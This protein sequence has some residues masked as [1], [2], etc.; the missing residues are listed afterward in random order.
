M[1]SAQPVLDLRLLLPCLTAWAV[2]AWALSWSGA[3][4]ATGVALALALLAV[5]VAAGV[6]YRG[7]HARAS[8]RRDGP[9]VLALTLVATV[10]V[11]GSSAAHEWRRQLGPV[12]R[13]AERGAMVRA[14]GVVLT[15]PR[16]RAGRPSGDEG[17]EPPQQAYL[18]VRL[19]SVDSRGVRTRV[20][21]PVFVR[22]DAAWAEV[23]WHDRIELTGKLSPADAAAPEVAQL[24]PR[25]PPVPVGER[26]TVRAGAEHLRSGMREA[27]DPL[28]TDARALLPALVIGDTSM[29]PQELTDDMLVTGM[30]HLSAVSGSNVAVVLAALVGACRLGGVPRRWRPW[31]AGAGLAFF[32]VLAR[33]E[34]SVIRAATMGAIGLIGMSTSRRGAGTPVLCTAVLVLLAIDPW[35]ARSYGFVLSTLATLGL[36]LFVRPWSAAINAH[37]PRQLHLIGPAVAIPLAAQLVCG[38]VIVLL[39]GNVS[40]IAVVANLVAAPFVA[41]ATVLGVTAAL[42]AVV[43]TTVATL[44]GW[45]GTPFALVIAWTARVAADV[46]GGALPW[47]DGAPGALLLAAV[48]AVGILC[49][50]WVLHR[51]RASPLVALGVL[52]VLTTGLVPSRSLGWPPPG[53]RLVA[54]DVGQGDGL[55]LASGPRRAVLVDVGPED[56][57]IDGCLDRLGVRSLDAVVL[58]HF[59]ED[60]VAGLED[61]LGGRAV[62]AL[63]VTPEADPEW[64]ARQVREV[65]A[66][67]DVP[68]RTVVAGDRFELGEVSATAWWPARPVAGGSPANNASIVL[69]VRSGDVD[70]L[71]LGDIEREA[72]HAL[73]LALRRDPAM[74][75]AADGLEVLKMPHHGSSNLD[76]GFMDEVAAPVALISVGAD[77]DYGHPT[78]SALAWAASHASRT[79]RTDVHGDIA[80]LDGPRVVTERPG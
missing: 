26:S 60:H 3:Q 49:G 52:T 4:R 33:P 48:T 21:A 54:C 44:V 9:G 19:E 31:A 25:G 59:H 58:T 24:S 35:L 17:G 5:L 61:A 2:G 1:T 42:V 68:V 32:V 22:G 50:P 67:H 74:A 34:P 8:W 72:G 37:L 41:P 28:P 62:G 27:V 39:Q 16:V 69:H 38:P 7:R 11:L 79:L 46:P 45:L 53:W 73:L 20:H 70:A 75:A 77:N 18:R 43:S 14:E 30:S 71:L 64:A 55:V 76:E 57:D 23:G 78:P 12:D 80:V 10:L 36:L 63:L 29:T 56:S 51:A 15:E 6:R 40:L 65:A 66:E 13:L 47:P